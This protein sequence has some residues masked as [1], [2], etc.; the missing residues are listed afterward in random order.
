MSVQ[1]FKCLHCGNIAI[2]PFDSG[3]PL[4]CCGEKM[5][6]LV[7]NTADAAVEKHVPVVTVQGNTVHVA[8]GSV[9]HPMTPEHYITFVC[10][11]TKKGYQIAQLTPEDAPAA[12]FALAEGD[13]A[14]AAYEY[15][16]LHGLWKTE[17]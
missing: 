8:V 11:E 17:L 10:L 5:T 6:E 2:K 12:D 7:A 15:C 1:F 16:N 13:E 9:P 14:V 4:V 3:V